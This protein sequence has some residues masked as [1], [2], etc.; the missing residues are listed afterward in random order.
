MTSSLLR[1]ER[2]LIKLFTSLARITQHWFGSHVSFF[3]LAV[4][5][6]T[7]TAGRQGFCLRDCRRPTIL[8]IVIVFIACLSVATIATVDL[9]DTGLSNRPNKAIKREIMSSYCAA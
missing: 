2:K 9:Q 3:L 8:N 1:L 6:G 5:E 7:V 4:T